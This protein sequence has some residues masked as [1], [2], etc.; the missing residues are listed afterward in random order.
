MSRYEEALKYLQEVQTKAPNHILGINFY[1]NTLSKLD[2]FEEAKIYLESKIKDFPNVRSL[3]DNY[4]KLCSDKINVYERNDFSPLSKPFFIEGSYDIGEDKVIEKPILKTFWWDVKPNFGDWIGPLLIKNIFDIDCINMRN[5]KSENVLYTVGS[6]VQMTEYQPH[7]NIKVWGS[8]LIRP[9]DMTKPSKIFDKLD[10]TSILSLRG[11][12]THKELSKHMDIDEKKISFGDPALLLPRIYQPEFRS[13]VDKDI[14]I[15]PHYVHKYYF[16]SQKN[17]MENFNIVDV[18]TT[19]HNVIDQITS[20]KICI[21]SSLHGI[22]IAQAYGIPWIW[23]KIE[24]DLLT[25]DQH[26]DFKFFDF[27]SVMDFPEK[28]NKLSI[29]TKDIN[30]ENINIAVKEA[31]VMEMKN[32]FNGLVD[33]LSNFIYG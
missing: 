32:N 20:S 33:D 27:F 22:I 1:V 8:G 11:L 12:L 7:H 9:L 26:Q 10:A 23:L 14:C 15:V 4:V 30:V 5:K 3:K 6:V 29:Y 13:K 31:K 28:F 19:P 17:I 21:S 25:R 24:D 18:Q 2:R 16:L